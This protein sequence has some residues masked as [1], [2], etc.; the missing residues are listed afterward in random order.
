MNR[1]AARQRLDQL[2]ERGREFLG[3]DLAILGGAMTWV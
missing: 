3:C 2:W 1:Q